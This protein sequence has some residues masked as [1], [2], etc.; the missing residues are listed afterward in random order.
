[1]GLRIRKVGSCKD[2]CFQSIVLQ[3]HI[4]VSARSFEHDYPLV[5]KLYSN[6]QIASWDSAY[7][8][9]CR[10]PSVRKILCVMAELSC[11]SWTTRTMRALRTP[12][13][14]NLGQWCTCIHLFRLGDRDGGLQCMTIQV[15]RDERRL[16]CIFMALIL[17]NQKEAVEADRLAFAASRGD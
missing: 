10:E 11:Q 3:L 13:S 12:E 17:A 8:L 6:E 1:M 16:D 4:S 9:H 15:R 5:R 7:A 14:R 2:I